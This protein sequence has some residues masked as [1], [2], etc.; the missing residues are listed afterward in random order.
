MTDLIKWFKKLDTY[1]ADCTQ[2]K[3]NKILIHTARNNT[4]NLILWSLSQQE[5]QRK[6]KKL[7]LI[8]PSQH[9]LPIFI[10]DTAGTLRLTTMRGD[11]TKVRRFSF[12]LQKWGKQTNFM[13]DPIRIFINTMLN[14]Q[15]KNL[16]IFS[17]M[18]QRQWI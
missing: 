4:Y 7:L 18:L 8:L 2:H 5:T 15:K 1:Y 3:I 11:K 13:S 12:I 10:T 17:F 16:R 14:G 6:L 9:I